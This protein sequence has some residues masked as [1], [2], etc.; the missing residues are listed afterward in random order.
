MSWFGDAWDWTKKGVDRAVNF[1]TAGAWDAAKDIAAGKNVVG[2][3]VGNMG[4]ARYFGPAGQFVMDASKMFGGGTASNGGAGVDPNQVY[5]GAT[6][7]KGNEPG[8]GQNIQGF[9][10]DRS[11]PGAAEQYWTSVQGD[12]GSPTK[13]TEYWNSV[14]PGATSPTDTGQYWA[15]VQGAFNTPHATSNRADEAYQQFQATQ[16]ADM[17]PYFDRARSEG[18]AGLNT[19]YGARGMYGSS[20]ALRGLSDMYTKVGAEEAKANADYQLRRGETAGGLARG[21]DT[22]SLGSSQNELGWIT[23]GANI[24]NAADQNRLAQTLGYG[25]LA[26]A[27][28]QTEL[29]KLLGYG[30][31]A[32]MS[33]TQL[34]NRAND[35]FNSQLALSDRQAGTITGMGQAGQQADYQTMIEAIQAALGYPREAANQN[36]NDREGVL[37]DIGKVMAIFGGGK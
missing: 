28:D 32:T 14:A 1:S 30:N 23:G 8:V 35:A 24:S 33:D 15:G 17:S 22:S 27:A 5:Q 2:S 34:G 21:A 11:G 10:A 7:P 13:S 4:P 29:A 19:Q 18:A 12:A 26:G 16:P 9:N 3:V 6:V 31:L 20:A 25:S 37:G 36:T